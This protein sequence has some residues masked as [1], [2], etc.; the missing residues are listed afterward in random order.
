M[1]EEQR[2]EI[3]AL[4]AIYDMDVTQAPLEISAEYGSF[5]IQFRLEPAY[6]MVIDIFPHNIPKG[7]TNFMGERT[8]R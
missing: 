1:N 7:S 3:D 2:D 5:Y 6:P 8:S 4:I